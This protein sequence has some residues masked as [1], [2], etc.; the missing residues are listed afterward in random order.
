MR[1]LERLPDDLKLE[2]DEVTVT[3]AS[4]LFVRA[5]SQAKLLSYICQKY[6][7]GE[8]DQ[9][10]E[11][12]IAVE[13]FKRGE[14]FQSK[15]DPIVRVEANRLRA[16]LKDYYRTEGKDRP[17]Q[18]FIPSGQYAPVFQHKLTAGFSD[19]SGPG[20]E[21][22]GEPRRNIQELDGNGGLTPIEEAPSDE[23]QPQAAQAPSPMSETAAVART[24]R[25][26]HFAAFSIAGT[27]LIIAAIIL[28]SRYWPRRASTVPTQPQAAAALPVSALPEGPELRIMAGS[29]VEKYVDRLGR[30][31]VGDRYFKGG[32][33]AT[34]SPS[35]L[36]RAEDSHLCKFSRQ[37]DFEYDI[38]AKPG[39]YELHLHFVE[40]EFGN[41]PEEGGETSRL[42]NVFVNERPILELFDVYSDAGG[43]GRLD[44]RVF[45][46]IVP[47][48]DGLIHISFRSFKSKAL[49]NGLEL[50]PGQPGQMRP[51]RIITRPSSYLSPDQRLWE[52]DRY[53]SGGRSVLRLQAGADQREPELYQSERYGNFAYAIPVARG[54]YTLTLKFAETYFGLGPTNPPGEGPGRRLFD[55]YCNGLALLKNFDVTLEAGGKNRSLDKVFHGLEPNAQGKLVLSFVPVKNYACVNALEIVPDLETPRRR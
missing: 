36:V 14:D 2:K 4:K 51:V 25:P 45:T 54:R 28:L 34:A 43:C 37:G 38:P 44:E 47:A 18:I 42:F 19:K 21:Q 22:G 16:R 52:S 39:V 5:P 35:S 9:I 6:F 12:T 55:V 24:P 20:P 11:Y 33:F 27:A 41:E 46:D 13:L 40:M 30:V 8:V 7:E 26:L 32:E 3:L 23:R 31:W 10:K 53:F 1:A 49:V 48:A 15:E 50:F 17:V 29:K